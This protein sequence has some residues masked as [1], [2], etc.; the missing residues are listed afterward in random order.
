MALTG[1]QIKQLISSHTKRLQNEAVKWDR[2]HRWYLTEFWSD[3]D[4]DEPANIDGRQVD[5]EDSRDINLESNYPF[6]FIDTM[7][8][9]VCPTNPMVSVRPRTEEVRQQAKLREQLINDTFKQ[10]DLHDKLWEQA[11]QAAITGRA[12]TKVVWNFDDEAPRIVAVDPRN[13]FWDMTNPWKDIE[14]ACEI[15]V[16][17]KSEFDSRV[18]NEIGR[19]KKGTWYDAAVARQSIAGSYPEWLKNDHGE[20][21]SLQ[22]GGDYEAF[23]WVVVYEF[24]D[25]V[26]GKVYHML[27]D[28]SE[29]LLETDLPL[30]FIDNPFALLVFNKNLRDEGGVSDIKLIEPLQER[31]NEID[32]LELWHA[33]T[34]IV[35][36]IVNVGLTQDPEETMT[37]LTNVTRPGQALGLKG[38]AG[39][40]IGD[41][42]QNSNPPAWSPQW[43]RMRERCTS[44]IEFTLGLPQYAR[45]S[46]GNSD[47]AT[48]LALTDAATRTRNGRRVKIVQDH[49]GSIAKRV[50][51]VWFEFL[52][53]GSPI[54]VRVTKDQPD[55][56][57][58]R[59]SMGMGPL[60]TP[61]GEEIEDAF[62]SEGLYDFETIPYSPTENHK[63][64]QLQKL[65][66]YLEVLMQAPELVSQRLLIEKLLEL[67]GMSELLMDPE[68]SQALQQQMQAAADAAGGPPGG[69]QGGDVPATGAVMGE[70][71]QDMSLP[72]E[73]QQE[74]DGARP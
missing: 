45:G 20:E 59:E 52:K 68:E 40:S 14:Y 60:F 6:A 30:R 33:H 26:A 62:K 63:M 21:G 35:Y 64:T 17:K 47:V 58:D 7:I 54:Y 38:K 61:D 2:W 71:V 8:A 74:T 4:D 57:I 1:E 12:I 43:D 73:V 67:L 22:G 34:S 41:I 10:N 13:F 24:Y 3:G 27:D 39:A 32:T 36:Q 9:N 31:L 28:S 42:V 37:L 50:I 16:V 56:L 18:R 53:P 23:E 11:T 69:G 48:E 55:S 65:A 51:A 19:R 5:E 46:V 66:Q 49:I 70:G 29:F 15:T 44:L 25:F 72:A